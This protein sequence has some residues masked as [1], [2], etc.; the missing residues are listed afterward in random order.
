MPYRRT[1]L[2]LLMKDVFDIACSRLCS[3]VVL[4]C[5]SALAKDAPHTLNTLGCAPP[6]R[7]HCMHTACT[8]CAHGTHTAHTRRAHTLH[9]F[10]RYAAPLRVAARLP[11]G[12][13][14]RDE[15]DPA[16]WDHQ[17]ALAWLAATASKAPD[18]DADAV[19]DADADPTALLGVSGAFLPNAAV[20]G[21]FD[22]EAVMPGMSG[23][24]LCRLPEAELHVRIRKQIPGKQGAAL[25]AR[26]HGALWMLICDAKTRRRKPNGKLITDEMEAEEA[27]QAEAAVAKKN[28]MWKERE[29]SMREGST[30][31]AAEAM[32]SRM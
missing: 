30:L 15:R 22:A 3:T 9:I 5:V 27:R 16:L 28:A 20:E 8:R 19:A 24:D 12:P 6:L 14:E 18:A 13:M 29:A 32:A 2:T 4:A 17:T 1:K 10:Y 25:A 26:V 21:P 7:A 23:L 31:E 11:T